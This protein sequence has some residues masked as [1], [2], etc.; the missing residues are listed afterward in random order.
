MLIFY[1]V[2][3]GN[4]L[5]ELKVSAKSTTKPSK[6]DIPDHLYQFIA[7]ASLDMVDVEM[8]SNEQCYLKKIDRFETY[9]VSA[10]V[11]LGG[12]IFL[13]LHEGRDDERVRSFFQD[14][15]EMYMRYLMNTFASVDGPI[16]NTEFHMKVES[17]LR[18]L[19]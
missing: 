7:H 13:L 17:L 15:Q 9:D 2:Y 16:V 14:T 4:P 5:Y 8:W 19:A 11:T 18:K 6:F 3:Q 10:Y 1:I 12:R